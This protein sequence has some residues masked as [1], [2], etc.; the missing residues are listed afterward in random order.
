MGR[1]GAAAAAA[2]G[3][4]RSSTTAA[5]GAAHARRLRRIA[6]HAAHHRQPAS[7]ASGSS[8][9]SASTGSS[10]S[11]AANRAAGALFEAA[12]RRDAPGCAVCVVRAGETLYSRGF[13]LASLEHSAP[14]YPHTVFDIGSVSKQF[15]AAAVAKLALD[16]KLSLGD[17]VSKHLP[18]F[19]DY[20]GAELTVSH[21]LHHTSGVRDYL[22]TMALAGQQSENVFT[23]AELVEMICRQRNLNFP[24]G[25][26]FLYSNSGYILLA[27]IVRA[28]S[29][30]SLGE[31][32]QHALFAP[33]GMGSSFIYEDRTR[34]I[35][36]RAAGYAPA[37]VAEDAGA[38]FSLDT[39]WNFDVAGDGQ[40]YSTVEDLCRWDQALMAAE[41]TPFYDLMHEKVSLNHAGPDE[42]IDYALGLT[43]GSYRGVPTVGHGGAWAGYRAMLLRFPEHQMSI[44][45]TCN[46]GSMNPERL[47]QQTADIF[48][49]EELGPHEEEEVVPGDSSQAVAAEEATGDE[50]DA[51]PPV[52][53]IQHL[54]GDYYSA[55]LDVTYRL[56]PISD[57]MPPHDSL[58]SLSWTLVGSL[59]PARH[60]VATSPTRL[61][62]MQQDVA[63]S[64]EFDHEDGGSFK[65]HAGRV[66]NVLFQ[67]VS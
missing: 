46:L 6:E 61:E 24:P 45:I 3:S 49:A 26:E 20:P 56:A 29:G 41:G 66:K 27:A 60:L 28:V 32:A 50:G 22:T 2:T 34:V 37:S 18:D 16:G 35:P 36:H 12:V 7:P 31:F 42:P 62:I 38:Q 58:S 1:S 5:T 40:V 55:E 17:A 21:L 30:E 59:R 19:P 65:L 47:A 13:G 4:G 51:L 11:S 43:H 23:E 44:A 39:A 64:F 9:A 14:I 63:E 10:S 53:D 67:K 48:L 15:T 57:A 33:A 25:E 54:A 8:G 52:G